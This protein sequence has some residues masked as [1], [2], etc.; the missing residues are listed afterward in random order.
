VHEFPLAKRIIEIAS[1][2]AAEN[3]GGSVKNINLVVGDESGYVAE[4]IQLYFDLIS[5]GTPC[6]GAELRVER[7][8]PLLRCENCNTLFERKPFEF[9]C[10][11]CGEDGKPTEIGREFYVKSIEI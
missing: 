6:E 1:E 8:N 3:G 11:T 7:V 5:E 4:C 10:P 2:K 9:A